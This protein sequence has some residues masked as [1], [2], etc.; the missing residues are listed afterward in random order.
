MGGQ[1]CV[2]SQLNIGTQFSFELALPVVDHKKAQKITRQPIIG[3][4]GESPKILIVDDHEENR[5]VVVDLL[6]PL[7]FKVESAKNGC[8][9]LEKALSFQPDVIIV[10]LIMPNMDGF[11]LIRQL[12]Q[13]TKLKE[14][15]IIAS[16]ASVYEKDRRKSLTAGSNAFL[17]KPI[18]VEKLFE[19]LQH[20]LNLTWVYGNQMPESSDENQPTQMVLP[21]SAELEKLYQLSLLC[22]IDELEEQAALLVAS[23]VELKPFVTKMQ[24]FLKKYQIEE[25]S[26]WLEGN[27]K[28]K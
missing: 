5:A 27:I 2:S 3:I 14:K 9:G 13:Y 18:Q 22:D 20:H 28:E 6:S 25:L 8:E 12:R 21:P 15:I 1:L 23:D 17:P 26:E 4:K 11:E 19:Q 24:A 16:S 10:D 7:G